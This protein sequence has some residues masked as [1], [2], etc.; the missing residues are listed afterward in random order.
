MKILVTGGAGFI[1]SHV[2]D[3]LCAAGHT[4]HVLDDLSS[5]RRHNVPSQAVFHQVDLRAPDVRTLFEEERYDVLVHHAAQMDVRRSV[6][7]P[8]FDADVNLLGFLNLMEAGRKSGLQKVVFASTGGA[9]Y[10]EPDY[11]PQDEAHPMRP[12]SPYGI[13]KLATERYLYYY[14]Q[15]YGIGYVALR[16]ANVYGPRQNPHGE[17]GVVAIFTRRLLAGEQPVIYGDGE[18][19]RDFVYVGDV[20]RANMA[21][22]DYDASGAINVG[23]GVETDVN[24]L[25][26]ILRDLIAPSFDEVHA[27]AKPGEQRRSVLGYEKARRTL[28]WTPTI[29]LEEGL[30]RTVAWFADTSGRTDV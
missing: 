23:T 17:A 15:Q 25:Y 9:I 24:T 8:A 10:G 7:D 28:G 11:A 1:G 2:A 3:A 26:R 21:A 20:V 14:Q 13:T 29:S 18:Q 22:L 27:E 5:G 30:R 4:V 12:L 6:A 19:T 16:Y